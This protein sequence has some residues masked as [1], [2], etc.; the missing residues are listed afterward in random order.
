MSSDLF[1][2]RILSRKGST[3]LVEVMDVYHGISAPE[4]EAFFLAALYEPAR[5]SGAP[6]DHACTVEQM[7]D[8]DFV[9]DHLREYVAG[10]EVVEARSPA[11]ATY[12]VV[13][14]D[15]KWA[16]HLR[17]RL[18]WGT[19]SYDLGEPDLRRALD[20]AASRAPARAKR[21]A[22][23]KPAKKTASRKVDE[24]TAV[25]KRAVRR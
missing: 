21:T 14:T 22:S 9:V 16:E 18:T 11:Q 6:L 5:G 12:K 7:C 1:T 19:A 13:F 25:K 17:A 4:T 24:K 3:V 8:E 15:P 20:K 2:L 23:K 10:V